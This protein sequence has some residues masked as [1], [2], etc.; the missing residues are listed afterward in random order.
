M[1]DEPANGLDPEGIR[2]LRD[3][4]RAL[5]AEGRTV[6]LSSHVLAEVAQ[7]VDE[8]VVISHGQ[9]VTHSAAGGAQ[10]RRR[11]ARARALP[12]AREARRRA[13]R[14]GASTPATTAPTRS[15]WSARARRRSGSSR[16]TTASC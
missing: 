5:A 13:H 4:L 3:F 16:S 15:S 9:L 10:Q 2:W 6:L 8:V 11:A 12:A 7:T 1:L 14:A